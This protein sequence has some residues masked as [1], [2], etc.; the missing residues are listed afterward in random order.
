M[1]RRQETFK[2]SEDGLRVTQREEL[3]GKGILKTLP[4]RAGRSVQQQQLHVST[5]NTSISLISKISLGIAVFPITWTLVCPQ[6]DTGRTDTEEKSHPK[7]DRASKR[8]W[9]HMGT[10]YSEYDI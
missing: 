2:T 8:D 1:K 3:R 5:D 4:S 9:F 6:E 10:R 7:Q